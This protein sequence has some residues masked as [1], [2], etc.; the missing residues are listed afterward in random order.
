MLRDVDTRDGLGRIIGTISTKHQRTAQ[1]CA[2]IL[3]LIYKL[4]FT[5]PHIAEA[6][7]AA[8]R[9]YGDGSL[10]IALIRE[11]SRTDPKDYV[12]DGVGAENVGRFLVDLADHSPKLVSTNVGVLVPHFGGESYKIRNALVG[13]LGKLVAKA[14]KEVE[15]D[16]NSKSLRLRG[17]Q[18]MLEILLERCRDVSA[19]TR[20]RVLQV[21]AELC[22]EH[23]VP[24]GLW[25]EV[26]SVA[27]GRLED[28]SAMVRKSALN[29]LITMLQHNPFGPQLRVVAFEA[30]L[31]KYKEKLQGIGPSGPSEE[32][33][34]GD[35]VH[36]EAAADQ[37]ESVSDS[38]LPSSEE[39]K[40]KD[41]TVPDIG[42]LEQIRALVAS[43]EAG[44]QFSKC[45]TSLMPTLVQLLAS[46]SVTDVEY[47][48]LLLMRCRQFQI[49]GS[50]ACLRK[51]LPLVNLY[52]ISIYVKKIYNVIDACW[53]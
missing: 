20:S 40:E 45:I 35:A 13:V 29:L 38:C 4:D 26:A 42:N 34:D 9:K 10:A 12:R 27:S 36:G 53:N 49:D 32:V 2:S 37:E 43:L 18:A 15:G 16:R 30:T 28:K 46:S 50:E 51:M 3:H 22:E 7:A 23:A 17:K 8:E 47:T 19:Y 33:A 21:W 44:L 14:Y 52:R 31:E 25:N 39:Q 48:I 41:G 6:V 5:V 1:T 24:I 11:I